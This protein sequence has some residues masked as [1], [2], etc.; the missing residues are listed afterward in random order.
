M[1]NGLAGLRELLLLDFQSQFE[2]EK[3]EIKL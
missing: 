3:K 2:G 1:Y